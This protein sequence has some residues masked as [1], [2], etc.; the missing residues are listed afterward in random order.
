VAE[1]AD[2]VQKQVESKRILDELGFSYD[3]QHKRKPN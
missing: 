2:L 1:I 3:A